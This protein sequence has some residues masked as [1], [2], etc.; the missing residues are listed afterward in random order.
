MKP[1][2]SNEELTST[3]FGG[4]R[5]LS[6]RRFAQVGLIGYGFQQKKISEI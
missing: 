2:A 3:A 4:S 6:V 1:M 5:H